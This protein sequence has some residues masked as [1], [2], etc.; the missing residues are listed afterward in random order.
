MT[1]VT[2][3]ADI[4]RYYDAVPRPMADAVEVGPFTLFVPHADHGWQFYARPRLGLTEHVHGR[5]VRRCSTGRSSSAARATSSGSTR[6]RR[7]CSRPSDGR[8]AWPRPPA[9]PWSSRSAP[10]SCCR[11]TRRRARPTRESGC[12]PR[13]TPTWARSI[14]AVHAGFDGSDDVVARPVA[15]LPGADRAG[16][17]V[18]VAAY[19]EDGRVA[20]GGSAAPRGGAA[21]LMGIGVPPVRPAPG[22]GSAITR[23]LVGA[24]RAAGRRHRAALGRLRRRRE[25]LPPGRLRRRGHGLH[26]G[27]ARGWVSPSCAG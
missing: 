20:G 3:R 18:M 26:P 10:C 9:S 5:D 25:H 2:L 6:R 12:S 13:T 11:P 27:D 22:L 16:P 21:E 7:R 23:A 14:G 17:L 24:V 4:E 15:R 8:S 1:T 19:D